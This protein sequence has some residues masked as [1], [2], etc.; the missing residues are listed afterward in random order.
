MS[1]AKARA[2]RIRNQIP[3]DDVLDQY[4][5]TI[6]PNADR[7]QQFSCDLH[8]D[9]SDSK[10]SARFYPDS[11]SWHCFACSK[12]R[13][14]ISTVMEKEGKNFSEAC[15]YLERMYG[16]PPLPWEDGKPEK[17]D[18]EINPQ[19]EVSV[20]EYSKSVLKS[21]ESFGIG[22]DIPLEDLLKMWEVH[23]MLMYFYREGKVEEQ[24]VLKGFHKIRKTA[25]RLAREG[26]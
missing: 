4:G 9:G 20:E 3:L 21:L 5:Y 7:E 6:I 24:K 23:D 18:T 19:K 12:S 2:D 8:G 17:I 1:R 11:T 26:I 16:L 13:Y 10:P 25:F 22:K 14:A 15:S